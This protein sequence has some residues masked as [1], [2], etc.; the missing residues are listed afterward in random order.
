[1]TDRV[2]DLV[3]QGKSYAEVT[4]ADPTREF[5]AKWGD[6]ERFL[7]AVYAELGGEG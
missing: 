1:M 2:R 6:P 7:T 4:A 3:E 5:S